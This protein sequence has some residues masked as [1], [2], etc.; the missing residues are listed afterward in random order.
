MT[1]VE[2]EEVKS[3][4]CI[5]HIWN[6]NFMNRTCICMCVR[7]GTV[8]NT[9]CLQL[10]RSSR[11][12]IYGFSEKCSNPT[13]GRIEFNLSHPLLYW[14]TQ[15]TSFK[16]KPLSMVVKE[17]SKNVLADDI[18]LYSYKIYVSRNDVCNKK[19]RKYFTIDVVRTAFIK[20]YLLIWSNVNARLMLFKPI[21]HVRYMHSDCL[22]QQEG[23]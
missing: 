2:L 21:S 17:T 10:H 4:S 19:L 11:I 7:Q 22:T 6:K 16:L 8:F 9:T 1:K 18:R 14:L 20:E 15:V 23:S 5:S 13:L 12:Y 3:L